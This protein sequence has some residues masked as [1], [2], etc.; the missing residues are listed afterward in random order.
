MPDDIQHA[1]GF[2]TKKAKLKTKTDNDYFVLSLEDNK[3]TFFKPST[4]AFN[5]DA[6]VAQA[7]RVAESAEEGDWVEINYL[8]KEKGKNIIGVKIA[9]APEGVAQPK[10]ESQVDKDAYWAARDKSIKWQAA[11]RSACIFL[12]GKAATKEQIV[13]LATY[14]FENEPREA[15]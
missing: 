6:E 12:Q 13:E 15:E 2:L 4:E 5:A 3:F 9:G 14:L 8:Q 1:K 10:T 7:W 11:H